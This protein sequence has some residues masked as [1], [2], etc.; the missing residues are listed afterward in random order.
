M[1]AGSR[2]LLNHVLNERCTDP[3]CEV[4]NLDVAVQEEVVGCL[5][6]AFFL[7]GAQAVLKGGQDEYEAIRNTAKIL[8]EDQ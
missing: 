2:E 8:Y 5:E 6:A 1:M 7:A 3:D 4:H